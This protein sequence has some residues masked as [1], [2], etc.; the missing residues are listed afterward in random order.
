MGNEHAP[1]E[2]MLHAQGL[3][4]TQEDDEIQRLFLHRLD[5]FDVRCLYAEILH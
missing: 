3:E 2:Q 5:A 1:K 4:L